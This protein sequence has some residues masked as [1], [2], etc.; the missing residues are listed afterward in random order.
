MNGFLKP[1][2][3]LFLNPLPFRNGEIVIAEY[4]WP[5]MDVRAVKKHA[6]RSERFAAVTA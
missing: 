5:E 1:A 3:R 4:Y 2:T 6:T